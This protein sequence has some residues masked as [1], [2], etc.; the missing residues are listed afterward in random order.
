M[1]QYLI[2]L[3]DASEYMD[4]E[5]WNKVAAVLNKYRVRPI[6]GI[7]PNNRDPKMTGAYVQNK[8]FWDTAH[9]WIGQGWIPALHGY[10]HKYIT[11]DGGINPVNNYS[12]FAGVPYDE[13]A[14]KMREGYRILLEH[15]IRPDIFF[16][17]AHTYDENTI[18]ALKSET[19]IR[20]ISDTV[21]WDLYKKDE[22]TYIPLLAGRIRRIPIRVATFCYHPNT[23]NDNDIRRMDEDIYRNL[24]YFTGVDFSDVKRGYSITDKML[25]KVYFRYRSIKKRI[26]YMICSN[27]TH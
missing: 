22:I 3:D 23:M 13:Q 14:M 17:P 8:S 15:D 26:Y 18:L 7:I 20:C 27:K 4:V 24:R 2:R 5:K 16:A 6:F 21:A 10:D 12:E 25:Q 1:R 19:D 9:R 11:S